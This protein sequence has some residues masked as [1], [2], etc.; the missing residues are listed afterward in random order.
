MTPI[1]KLKDA[2]RQRP[3]LRHVL[4]MPTSAVREELNRLLG[5]DV[6]NHTTDVVS[7]RFLKIL[8]EEY[9]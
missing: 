7:R 9:V 4:Q 2:I 8:G 3:Q 5:S 1:K 6:E